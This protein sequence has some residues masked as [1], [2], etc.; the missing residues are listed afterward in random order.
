MV[1]GKPLYVA[2]AQR[3]DVRRAQM[4]SNL[5]ARM[6]MGGMARAPNPMAGEQPSGAVR[7]RWR[8]GRAAQQAQ[9]GTAQHGTH[10]SAARH[11]AAWHARQ[12]STRR[13]AVAK[14]PV[15]EERQP[16]RGASSRGRHPSTRQRAPVC[17]RPRSPLH[18]HGPLP[19][20]HALLR[21]WPRRHAGPPRPGHDV[22]AHDA[23]AR[24]AG[25]RPRPS[26]PYD[27]AA[28]AP[29]AASCKLRAMSCQLC[30]SRVKPRRVSR[31]GGQLGC[32][33]G[34]PLAQHT[35]PRSS[36]RA[37]PYRRRARPSAPWA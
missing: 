17:P 30:A 10:G 13:R 5:Q 11:S 21:G 25:R 37:G 18:R 26:R 35:R 15:P 33:C 1:K 6:G 9:H 34:P 23:P 20:R 24:H 8:L 3:K 28:G 29:P 4:E 14:R 36:P 2:L 16:P 32:P 7:A 31:C 19:R 22:P 12:R 27:A